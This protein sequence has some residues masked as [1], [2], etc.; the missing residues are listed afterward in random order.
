MSHE[1]SDD[2]YIEDAGA[3]VWSSP[4][5]GG[6]TEC[7]QRTMLELQTL[8]KTLDSVAA[9]SE[10]RIWLPQNEEHQQ[11]PSIRMHGM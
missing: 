10:I 5:L 3:S 8:H 11:N 6:V 1:T 7:L 4:S 9:S 2:D